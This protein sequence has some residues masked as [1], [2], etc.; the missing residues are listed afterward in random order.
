VAAGP[1][2]FYDAEYTAA[3][4]VFVGNMTPDNDTDVDTDRKVVEELGDFDADLSAEVGRGAGDTARGA[5]ATVRGSTSLGAQSVSASSE[6]FV[7]SFYPGGSVVGSTYRPGSADGLYQGRVFFRADG[8]TEVTVDLT[9]TLPNNFVAG[10]VDDT[11][12]FRGASAGVNGA[13]AGGTLLDFGIFGPGTQSGSRSVV[14]PAGEYFFWY[15]FR[16][17]ESAAEAAGFDAAASVTATF[18]GPAVAVPLPPALWSAAP[19]L[20]GCVGLAARY[21][22]RR[23]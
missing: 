15:D 5:A 18:E 13:P 22:R 11:F 23:A 7:N 14:V 12:G 16:V 1:V 21:A 9:A 6:M 8:P 2:V 20:L 4:N 17:G 10:D 3:A 19:C